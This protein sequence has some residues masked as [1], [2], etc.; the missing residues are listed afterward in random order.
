MAHAGV[1]HSAETITH[2]LLGNELNASPD[3]L[4]QCLTKFDANSLSHGTDVS[5]RSIRGF[6]YMLCSAPRRLRHE[7]GDGAKRVAAV[8]TVAVE[9]VSVRGPSSL[10]MR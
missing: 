8:F 4:Q 7:G 10:A 2:R 6:G 1:I 3:A 9:F 5:I